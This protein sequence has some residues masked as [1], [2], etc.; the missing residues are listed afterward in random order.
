[1]KTEGKLILW[2]WVALSAFISFQM[3]LLLYEDISYESLMAFIGWLY[4]F[5]DKLVEA[6]EN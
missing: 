5:F 2:W 3:S 6:L 4:I 1:M